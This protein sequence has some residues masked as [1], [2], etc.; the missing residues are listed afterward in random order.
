MLAYANFIGKRAPGRRSASVAARRTGSGQRGAADGQP[1][2][3]VRC[4]RQSAAH[5]SPLRAGAV[6]ACG[7]NV[8]A[9]DALPDRSPTR[10]GYFFLSSSMKPFEMNATMM[11]T[12]TAT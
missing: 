2:P 10:C 4:D 8:N 11:M 9:V 5:S 1:A 7:S 12:M 6:A 3:Q